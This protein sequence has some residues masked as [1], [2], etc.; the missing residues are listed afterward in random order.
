MSEGILNTQQPLLE[1]CV[2]L[3]PSLI[4]LV[5]IPNTWQLAIYQFCIAKIINIINTVINIL[6]IFKISSK[7]NNSNPRYIITSIQLVSINGQGQDRF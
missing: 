4:S 5:I 6:N 3:I 7:L 1:Y 2:S